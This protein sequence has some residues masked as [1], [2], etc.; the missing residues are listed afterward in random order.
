[1]HTI[2]LEIP[3]R[4]AGKLAA[5]ALANGTDLATYLARDVVRA[6]GAGELTPDHATT[7]APAATTPATTTTEPTTHATFGALR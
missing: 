3:L 7:P 1:M 2:H 4:D 5:L 6:A